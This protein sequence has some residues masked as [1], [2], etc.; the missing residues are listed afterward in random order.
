M[1]WKK[2]V[3]KYYVKYMPKYSIFGNFVKKWSR[4]IFRQK[5]SEYKYINIVKKYWVRKYERKV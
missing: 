2:K 5:M 1:S 3:I 4:K